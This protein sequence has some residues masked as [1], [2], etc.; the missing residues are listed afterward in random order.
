MESRA[1]SQRRPPRRSWRAAARRPAIAP[2]RRPAIAP[3]LFALALLGCAKLE[4]LP[5]NTCGNLTHEPEA[6]EDCDGQEGCGAPGTDRACRFV[7]DPP[8]GECPEKDKGYSCGVD[9]VCRRPSGRFEELDGIVNSFTRDLLTADLNNDGCHEIVHTTLRGVSIAAIGSDRG[10]PASGQELPAGQPPPDDHSIPPSPAL[11]DLT[12]DGLPELLVSARG[13]YGDGLFV[14]LAEATPTVTPLLYPTVRF[15][16]KTL[17]P[18]G[19]KQPG[20]DALYV[21]L[22]LGEEPE[23]GMPPGG[24]AVAA[25]KDPRYK[26]TP[27]MG[28]FSQPLSEIVLLAAADFDPP[29]DPAACDEILVGFKGQ[30]KIRVYRTCDPAGQPAFIELP[31]I[32]LADGAKLR[33]I[34]AAIA[35]VDANQDGNPDLLVNTTAAELHLAFGRG[36]GTFHSQPPVAGVPS[37]GLTSVVPPPVNDPVAQQEH[38]LVVSP[39]YRF[40]AGDVDK[41]NALPFEV[42]ALPCPAGEATQTGSPGCEKRSPVCESVVDDIDADGNLDVVF[43]LGADPSIIIA[44]GGKG[45]Q[46][47][48]ALLPT[49]CPPHGLV[50]GDFDGDGIHDVAFLDPITVDDPGVEDA[51]GEP[52]KMISRSTVSIAY[53]RAFAVPEAPVESGSI[54]LGAG[55]TAG[56]FV[57]SAPGLQ[58]FAARNIPTETRSPTGQGGPDQ[59]A[60]KQ[61]LGGGVALVTDRGERVGAAPL[62]LP[63]GIPG[64]QNKENLALVELAAVATGQFSPAA[65]QDSRFGVAVITRALSS[66]LSPAGQPGTERL[67]RLLPHGGGG[68]SLDPRPGAEIP[69]PPCDACVLVALNTD[70]DDIQEVLLL[71]GKEA[72][73]YGATEDTFTLR[74]DFALTRSFRSL[75]E[76]D[77]TPRKYAPRPLVADLDGDGRD[78]VLL[79]ATDGMLVVLIGRKDGLFDEVPLSEMAGCAGDETCPFAGCAGNESCVATLLNA[80]AD[81][82]LELF[83]LTPAGASLHD[84]DL[85]GRKLRPIGAQ[86][87]PAGLPIDSDF[88]AVRAGDFDGDGVDDLAIMRTSRFTAVMRGVPENE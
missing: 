60:E 49:Q 26:A 51:P 1:R 37:D 32:Q 36:D 64:L 55:L 20:P 22:Q 41:T 45:D 53:G 74:A 58:L 59:G 87:W 70:G 34:N 2:A 8:H 63:S 52:P 62:Y 35:V 42:R 27:M 15:V 5:E 54:E 13:F 43:T 17:R 78:D 81:A 80:D 86:A 50:S 10:C 66:A 61:G 9:G 18:L 84:I 65:E 40:V 38:A 44:R 16:E 25:V 48:L 88:T 23:G 57:E 83:A 12:N 28:S 76:D 19:V 33:D 11:A 82:A 14:H 73:V 3:A 75:A 67:W 4:T 7:C 6:G 39:E 85:A 21:F 71:A 56:K 69:A 24:T 68:S 47:H 79:R 31:G 77:S 29:A 46:P 30:P 72:F